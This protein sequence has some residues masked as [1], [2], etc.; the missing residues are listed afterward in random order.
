MAVK[1]RPVRTLRGAIPDE[2]MW[3]VPESPE[4]SAVQ[5]LMHEFQTH[6]HEE[7][8]WL[9]IYRKTARETD[10]PAVRFLLDLIVADE[11][12]HRQLIARM[13][14]TLKDDLASTASKHG[15]GLKSAVRNRGRE[16]R[17]VVERF[18]E[19]ER[20]GIEEYQRLIKASRDLRQDL[21][22]L[23][24]KTMIHDSLKHIDILEF[25]R[26]KLIESKGGARQKPIPTKVRSIVG[27]R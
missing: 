17:V 12:R 14:S 10:E 15:V 8:R 1:P 3:G 9:E 11:E 24:C 2:S 22:G 7:E 6:E 13:V 23:L 27:R 16:M 20:R 25:L 18:L 5:R 19:L 4:F 26:F 21:F